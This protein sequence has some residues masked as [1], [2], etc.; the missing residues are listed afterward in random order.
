MSSRMMFVNL[1][2]KD[3]DRA[4]GFF[5]AL[6]FGFNPRFTDEKAACLVVSELGFVMLIQEA[7]FRTFTR[8]PLCDSTRETEGLVA[9]SCESRAEVDELARRAIGAGGAQAMEPVDH[10]FMYER[11]FHDPDGHHWAVL[12]MDPKAARGE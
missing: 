9:L 3:L 8:R 7:F 11:S 5:A 4:K 2:V 12:W 10:G 6:G 1:P